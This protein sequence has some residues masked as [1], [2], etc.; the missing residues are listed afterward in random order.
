[1][2]RGY[3]EEDLNAV[4]GL[5]NQLG[6]PTTVDEMQQRMLRL[7]GKEDYRTVV[8]AVNGEVAGYAGLIKGFCWEK[9]GCFVRIQA[10][11]VN[12][13]YRQTGIGKKLI[14]STEQ[15][16]K[17]IHAKALILNCGINPEREG[18]RLFYPKI[19]FEATSKGYYRTID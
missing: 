14:A 4:T 19:G 5:T 8:A 6:Y 12:S 13:N 15:W 16:A 3:R 10:L 1:M 9:N 2:I 18:A 17:A 11:V 7:S